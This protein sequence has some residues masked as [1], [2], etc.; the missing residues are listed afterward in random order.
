MNTF[1]ASHEKGIEYLKSIRIVEALVEKYREPDLATKMGV[2][3]AWASIGSSDPGTDLLE[4]Y[5]AATGYDCLEQVIS[6]AGKEGTLQKVAFF[7]LSLFA[8]SE[9]NEAKLVSSGW[10]VGQRGNEEFYDQQDEQIRNVVCLP[11]DLTD[12]GNTR[13]N[14]TGASRLFSKS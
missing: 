1:L 11:N 5:K 8:R 9:K 14:F 4:D 13:K 7:S 3:M 2:I 10:V 6:E 12:I